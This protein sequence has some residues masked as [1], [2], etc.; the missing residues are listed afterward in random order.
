[1]THSTAFAPQPVAPVHILGRFDSLQPGAE[2]GM[3]ELARQLRAHTHVDLWSDH[4]A[5]P[6][7]AAL[8][9]R[10]ITTFG[11][12]FP[13]RGTLVMAGT[14][15]TLGLWAQSAKFDRVIIFY[16]L[17]QH[18][19]LFS[20]I[21]S[22]R[23]QF[24]VDPEL[25][26]ASESLKLSTG[27]LGLVDYSPI[28]LSQ[29]SAKHHSV[30]VAPVIGRMS[31]D[32]PE[33]F[34]ADDAKLYA[35]LCAQGARVRMMGAL[36]QHDALGHIAGVELLAYGAQNMAAFFHS[37]DIFFYRTGAWGETYGRVVAEAMAAGLPV[38]VARGGGYAELIEHGV[39]GYV[40]DNQSQAYD[41][42]MHLM[43]DPTL[44]A[45]MGLAAHES[46]R[47][48]EQRCLTRRLAF[49]NAATA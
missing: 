3:L 22:L 16:N 29:Y 45:Q 34:H 17:L 25:M 4:P 39:T 18:N 28:D 35:A 9:I 27:L 32:V 30:S 12:Q 8:G 31:R 15:I 21:E 10:T 26:F 6:H 44:R 42:L 14:H 11:G 2:R 7:Y 40:V 48:H 33:K 37:L 24:N 46:I 47:Q 1:M 43:Q 19:V 38:V 36:C 5:H 41:A 13:N 20:L 49:F 23:D